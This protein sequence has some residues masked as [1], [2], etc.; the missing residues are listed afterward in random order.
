MNGNHHRCSTCICT[1][2]PIVSESLNTDQC[3]F[4]TMRGFKAMHGFRTIRS[5][6]VILFLTCKIYRLLTW[7]RG[8]GRGSAR[9]YWAMDCHF[10]QALTFSESGNNDKRTYALD[11][12]MT[13][14]ETVDVNVPLQC[15]L[16]HRKYVMVDIDVAHVQGISETSWRY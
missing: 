12:S 16:C 15:F 14:A 11:G 7:N 5:R 6:T 1:F 9:M 4:G 2:C 13:V 3:G 8:K 10:R